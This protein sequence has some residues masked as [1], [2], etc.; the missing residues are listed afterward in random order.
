MNSKYEKLE[1]WLEL[2]NNGDITEEEFNVEKQKLLN[3]KETIQKNQSASKKSKT[4]TIILVAIVIVG[5]IAAIYITINLTDKIKYER[6]EITT[7]DGTILKVNKTNLNKG[8]AEIEK[9]HS[10]ANT[11]GVMHCGNSIVSYIVPVFDSSKDEPTSVWDYY[12]NTE[13]LRD[14]HIYTIFDDD[15]TV[16]EC[17]YGKQPMSI[18]SYDMEDT[19]YLAGG[20]IYDDYELLIVSY[21]TNGNIK[22]LNELTNRI[23]DSREEENSD[24][25]EL[26]ETEQT[27]KDGKIYEISDINGSYTNINGADPGTEYHLYTINNGNVEYEGELYRTYKGTYIIRDNQLLITYT[28]AY[29]TGD[30]IA[31]DKLVDELTI[32]NENK[33]IRADGTVFI[34][35]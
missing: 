21:E 26:T 35:E 22:I 16:S 23:K 9:Q 3:S 15:G 33:L 24:T 25:S 18:S 32:E 20:Y 34:K 11:I 31:L 5:I 29:E 10:V 2:R 28:E 30:P 17:F 8:I 12:G 6:I 14:Y 7:N 19:L 1:K 13:T 4:L 27:S